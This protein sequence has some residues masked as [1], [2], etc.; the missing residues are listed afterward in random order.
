MCVCGSGMYMRTAVTS[1]CYFVRARN[2][3]HI[4]NGGKQCG[5]GIQFSGV[6]VCGGGR[7]EREL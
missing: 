5:S 6:Y 7:E 2:I 1:D 4:R 3:E